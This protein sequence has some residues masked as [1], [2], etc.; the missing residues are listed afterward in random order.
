MFNLHQIM[1]TWGTAITTESYCNDKKI[2]RSMSVHWVACG[3]CYSKTEWT[4]LGGIELK[5]S[6]QF[7]QVGGH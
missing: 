4:K 3:M 6:R 7:F 5:H 2:R 1:R